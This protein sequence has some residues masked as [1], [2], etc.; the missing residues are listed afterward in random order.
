MSRQALDMSSRSFRSVHDDLLWWSLRYTCW[1]TFFTSARKT[2]VLSTV[3]LNSRPILDMLYPEQT[4]KLLVA[5]T[6]SSRSIMRVAMEYERK[7]Q[8]STSSQIVIHDTISA[9]ERQSNLNFELLLELIRSGDLVH[10]QRVYLLWESQYNRPVTRSRVLNIRK[11]I[12][13]YYMKSKIGEDMLKIIDVARKVTEKTE[14]DIRSELWALVQLGMMNEADN[15]FITYVP[16]YKKAMEQQAAFICAH[17]EDRNECDKSMYLWALYGFHVDPDRILR[18]EGIEYIKDIIGRILSPD[19]VVRNIITTVDTNYGNSIANIAIKTL[20]DLGKPNLA[21]NLYRDMSSYMANL[22]DITTIV[23][24]CLKNGYPVKAAKLLS[25][26]NTINPTMKDSDIMVDLK[27]DTIAR[28]GDVDKSLSLLTSLEKSHPSNILNY[29]CRVLEIFANNYRLDAVLFLVKW[30]REKHRVLTREIY[31]KIIRA[32]IQARNSSGAVS[33]Y[34]KARREG[35]VSNVEMY[36]LAIIS[37]REQNSAEKMFREYHR[38]IND[39]YMPTEAVI[40]SLMM[41]YSIRGDVEMTERIFK[42]CEIYAVKPGN[43]MFAALALAH[44]RRLQREHQAQFKMTFAID[45]L[46]KRMNQAGIVPD[47]QLLSIFIEGFA[48]SSDLDGVRYTIDFMRSVGQQITPE[49]Y[50]NLLYFLAISGSHDEAMKVLEQLPANGIKRSAYH[51]TYLMCAH[52]QLNNPKA[53]RD[54]FQKLIKEDLPPSFVSLVVILMSMRLEKP[55]ITHQALERYLI[56]VTKD[57]RAI[58]DNLK[59]ISGIDVLPQIMFSLSQVNQDDISV[60]KN[61]LLASS[62]V[63]KYSNGT[64]CINRAFELAAMECI[65]SCEQSEWQKTLEKWNV[66]VTMYAKQNCL[67]SPDAAGYIKETYFTT[68]VF[69]AGIMKCVFD[70]VLKAILKSEN[71]KVLESIWAEFSKLGLAFTNEH[72]NLKLQIELKH[73]NGARAFD[74]AGII[75]SSRSGNL[76]SKRHLTN[77]SKELLRVQLDFLKSSEV[78]ELKTIRRRGEQKLTGYEDVYMNHYSVIRYLDRYAD[79]LD[80]LKV[81]SI[82]K[83]ELEAG[84]ITLAEYNEHMKNYDQR[85]KEKRS[86]IQEEFEKIEIKRERL[87]S[88]RQ[89]HANRNYLTIGELIHTRVNK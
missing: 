4:K 89:T 18:K 51:Y 76:K 28:L 40:A 73:E 74:T 45:E 63:R 12:Y 27:V 53:V 58:I 79:Y 71:F 70:T 85:I 67:Y 87:R 56:E 69:D 44:V 10:S 49:M 54:L 86:V 2:P 35:I 57:N 19:V 9:I 64:H 21:A 25:E 72:W 23:I 8:Y 13:G 31:T 20:C 17:H 3:S 83:A 24:S 77:V 43:Q 62:I 22:D 88:I 5:M 14:I 1:K 55:A 34:H 68:D 37:Y 80:R 52:Y 59:H 75:L 46:L 60:F 11:L 39:G 7:R 47:K 26:Y 29:Y 66:V 78:S 82:K 36:H 6:D 81:N 15:L 16:K 48:C 32:H 61:Y 30:Y 33:W 65:D 38:M 84:N 50:G 41:F 42:Y